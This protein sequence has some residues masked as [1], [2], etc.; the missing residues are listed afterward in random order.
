MEPSI[1]FCKNCKKS[2]NFPLWCSRCMEVAYCNKECQIAHLNIHKFSCKC[3]INRS[4]CSL[5]TKKSDKSISCPCGARR[6]C[7][8]IHREE[9]YVTHK[10]CCEEFKLYPISDEVTCENILRSFVS[11]IDLYNELDYG[12]A[13]KASQFSITFLL[14]CYSIAKRKKLGVNSM[15]HILLRNSAHIPELFNIISKKVF[16]RG[17]LVGLTF[18]DAVFLYATASISHYT[19][20][21]EKF[22]FRASNAI[23]D[24]LTKSTITSQGVLL[25]GPSS[26]E[27]KSTKENSLI[28]LEEK[29]SMLL[30]GDNVLFYIDSVKV[31]CL[32]SNDIFVLDALCGLL[33]YFEKIWLSE[34][35]KFSL[36][37]IQCVLIWIKRWIKD[38]GMS[39]ERINRISNNVAHFLRILQKKKLISI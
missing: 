33:C 16:S 37:P 34:S 8:N 32:S 30:N 12:V 3:I 11:R 10:P 9:D 21:V 19:D 39:Y 28:E 35:K 18:K 7:C 20:Y 26:I 22:V 5:C 25:F 23:L 4:I 36:Y 6:Y 15:L 29:Y 14:Y 1:I 27:H 24:I 13:Q 17:P 31:V 38:E 2:L